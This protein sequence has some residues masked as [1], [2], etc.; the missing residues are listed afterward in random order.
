[1][2][3]GAVR[4]CVE[5]DDRSQIFTESDFKYRCG[6]KIYGS[7]VDDLISL[8]KEAIYYF[9]IYMSWQIN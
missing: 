8:C 9:V 5:L 1:M 3:C 4:K 2:K 7:N 6:C